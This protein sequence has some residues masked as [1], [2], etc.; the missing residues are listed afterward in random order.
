MPEI[1]LHFAIPFSLAKTK[2]SLKQTL[3]VASL[4]LVP[5]MDVLLRIH[6]SMTHSLVVATLVSIPVLTGVYIKKRKYL[7]LA[8]ACYLAIVSHILLDV[9]QTYTPIL[10]PVLG[11]SIRV[12]AE[13]SVVI[14]STITP[15]VTASVQTKPTDFTVFQTLDAPLYTSE[16][17]VSSAMLITV[18][19]L[20]SMRLRRFRE[21]AG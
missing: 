1:L 14:S 3:L 8:A 5:D 21:N 13:G 9:F 12:K 10:Y 4:A 17:L 7:A 15:R 16:G 2:F 20:L 19:I 6:R 18:P 11:E